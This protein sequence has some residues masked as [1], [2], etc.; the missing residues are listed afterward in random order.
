MFIGR[1]VLDISR[2]VRV[3]LQLELI[4]GTSP[5]RPDFFIEEKDPRYIQN[6]HDFEIQ[7]MLSCELSYILM[8][9]R[10]FVHFPLLAVHLEINNYAKATVVA[11]QD[12]KTI[13]LP[14]KFV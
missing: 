9:A 14:A 11:P 3:I 12:A 5:T 8:R 2:Q 6:N 13:L 7:K 10:N 1:C 4:T